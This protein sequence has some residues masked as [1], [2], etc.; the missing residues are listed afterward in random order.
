MRKWI[1]A[2]LHRGG[3]EREARGLWISEA[4]EARERPWRGL[5][6]ARVRVWWQH[7]T[8]RYRSS[9][10]SAPSPRPPHLVPA[11][12][13][14]THHLDR[15][16]TNV[17]STHFP[18]LCI[19][20]TQPACPAPDPLHKLVDPP[21]TGASGNVVQIVQQVLLLLLKQALAR[22]VDVV[23]YGLAGIEAA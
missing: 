14:A 3:G 12:P 18:A 11:C 19:H 4:R 9:L 20:R 15:L 10:L 2:A 21:V 5:R 22:G 17:L 1:L 6:R 16:H 23:A 8:H 7:S 13:A